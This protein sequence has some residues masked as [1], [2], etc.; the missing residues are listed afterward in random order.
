MVRGLTERGIMGI[1][2]LIR[3][4]LLAPAVIGVNRRFFYARHY[5][6]NSTGRTCIGGNS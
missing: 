5:K 1:I 2:G 4:T 3:H 6:G